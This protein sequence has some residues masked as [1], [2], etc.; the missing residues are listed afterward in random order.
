MPPK[1][2]ATSGVA[3][4]ATSGVERMAASYNPRMY[5]PAHFAEP[6]PEA[7]AALMRDHSLATLVTLSARGVEANP[8]P[9]RWHPDR[10][11]LHGHLARGNPLWKEHPADSDV[12]AVFHGPQ[13]Y[14][15]PNWYP[16]KHEHGKAVPTW[17]YLT[18]QARG[19]LRVIDDAEW[20]RAFLDELTTT[21][22]ASEPQPWQM[23]DAPP[24][25]IDA[26]LKAVV[27]IVIEVTELTGKWKASQNQ[28]EANR[29]GV[30]AALRGHNE[31]MADAVSRGRP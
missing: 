4:G 17:N 28:S 18:V 26:M 22:E 9:L 13:A 31:L 8:V 7:H 23:S 1:R 2:R 24:D 15:S 5:L 11:Q 30:V 6:D 20:K 14:V 25:Y 3:L 16:T 29:A 21:H 12:L 27:G 10:R 19:R